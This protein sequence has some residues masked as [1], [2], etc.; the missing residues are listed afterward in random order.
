MLDDEHKNLIG[1]VNR[2]EYAIETRDFTALLRT[3]KL[4]MRCVQIHFSN[5]ERFAQAINF[6]FDQHKLAHQHLQKELQHT[7]N[8]LEA[9][10]G[11]WPDYVMDH[12][13][14][15]LRE[16]LIE[17]ITKECRQMKQVLQV[18]PYDYKPG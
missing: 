5:E 7:L 2:I 8:Q 6:P 3:F 14:Q 17:R 10:N 12:Y 11:I 16:L 15:F 18:Y 13:P 4:L 9:R 1:I